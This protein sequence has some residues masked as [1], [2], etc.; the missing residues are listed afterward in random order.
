MRRIALGLAACAL[1]SVAIAQTEQARSVALFR[2][3]G[4]VL[5]HPRCLNCHPATD[6]P[7]Q[8]DTMRPHMPPI[9]RGENDHGPPG[10]PCSACHPK[11]NFDPAGVPGHPDWH[12][13]PI[14]MAWQGKS[15]GEICVQLKDPARNGGKDLPALLRHMAEDTLVGWAWAPGRGRTSAPGTQGEFGALLRA[16]AD[17]GAHCPPG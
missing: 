14:S 16:W 11:A 3:A 1:S 9:V 15:L 10:L 6:R 12:L 8:A 7:T 13:A 17:S 2:E 5:Q 4:K